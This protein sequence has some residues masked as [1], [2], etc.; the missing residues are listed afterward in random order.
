MAG[1]NAFLPSYLPG[2]NQRFAVAPMDDESAH[3]AYAGNALQ[4]SRICALHHTRTLSKDLVLSF[5]RQRYILQTGGAPRYALRGKEVTVVSYADGR[6][7]ILH[8]DELLP[9]KAFDTPK[10]ASPPVDEKTINARVDDILRGRWSEKSRPAPEHP[11]RRYPVVPVSWGGKL[12]T[13]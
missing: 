1:A 7:E 8:G 4:L 12:A 6:I 9:F 5:N 11:W 3:Q 10:P 2:H 13:P